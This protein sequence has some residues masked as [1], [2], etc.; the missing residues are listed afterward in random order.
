MKSIRSRVV[1]AVCVVVLAE[2]LLAFFLTDVTY[3]QS[4]DAVAVDTI[5]DARIGFDALRADRV[6]RMSIALETF[7]RDQNVE[8]AF[9]ARDRERL[10][11]ITGPRFQELNK[12]LGISRLYFFES[13]GTV[14][15]RPYSDQALEPEGFGDKASGTVFQNSVASGGIA[16]GFQQGHTMM[17]L[18]VFEPFRDS[19]GQVI[20]YI[21]MAETVDEYLGALT[22][23][24]GDEYA[25]FL[26]KDGLDRASWEAAQ[27][28]AGLDGEWDA[29]K[30]VVLAEHTL[31]TLDP[32]EF[33][34][35][36]NV[37]RGTQSL[38]YLRAEGA[39]YTAGMFPLVDPNGEQIGEIYML[40]DVTP[41][42]KM[43][44][45]SQMGLVAA[46][47]ALTVLASVLSVVIIERV[48]LK[49]IDALVKKMQNMSL[50]A[51]SGDFDGLVVEPGEV[52]DDEIGRFEQFFAEF[53][54]V[55]ATV[56]KSRS[57]NGSPR[58]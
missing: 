40:H 7:T 10:L 26:K 16:S 5:E 41:L 8:A 36:G 22:A 35:G 46:F 19:A 25:L 23:K 3:R 13:D 49:R 38:G 27:K 29:Y 33:L 55:I 37:M 15:L 57:G 53:M 14:F 6:E 28:K 50:A 47:L 9:A 2:A 48:A 30:D 31:S 43:L 34:S 44:R 11:A 39:E 17:S 1:F 18:R 12:A 32:L 56:L 58:S 4:L 45:R 52:V 51:A 54:A 24:T 21:G 42:G 20:G